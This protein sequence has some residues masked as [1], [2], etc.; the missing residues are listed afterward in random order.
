MA[1]RTNPSTRF[2]LYPLAARLLPSSAVDWFVRR[3]SV[4]DFHLIR[5][6]PCTLYLDACKTGALDFAE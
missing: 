2:D 3:P 4:S 1:K 5:L 6:I